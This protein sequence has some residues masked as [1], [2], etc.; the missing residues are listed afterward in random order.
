MSLVLKVWPTDQQLQ[1]QLGA[2]KKCRYTESECIFFLKIFFFIWAIF[3]VFI[4][5]V[6]RSPGDFKT[7]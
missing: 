3:K 4:E 2:Y 6:T 7:H 5:S 1:H